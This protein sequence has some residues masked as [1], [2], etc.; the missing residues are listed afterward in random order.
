MF[1]EAR[2]WA[3]RV[4]ERMGLQARE[5]AATELVEMMIN[6]A[7]MYK[8][9]MRGTAGAQITQP[10]LVL[11]AVAAMSDNR[12]AFD[13]LK[14]ARFDAEQLLAQARDAGRQLALENGFHETVRRFYDRLPEVSAQALSQKPTPDETLANFQ[15]QQPA[16]PHKTTRLRWW[17]PLAVAAFFGFYHAFSRPPQ[18]PDSVSTSPGQPKQQVNEVDPWPWRESMDAMRSNDGKTN[19][20]AERIAALLNQPPSTV[21]EQPSNFSSFKLPR[22]VEVQIPKGWW[23]LG[24]EHLRIIATTVEAAM[25][26]S[27]VGLP[28]GQKVTLIAANSMPRSTYAAIRINSTTPPSM[29]RTDVMSVTTAEIA[30]ARAE[31]RQNLAKLLQIQG[32]QLLEVLGVRVETIGG[33]PAM[34]TEY[35]RTGPEGAVWAQINQVFTEQQEIG[36]NLSYRESEAMLW[37]PVVAKMRQ[38]I[39]VKP[40]R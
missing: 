5:P 29:T 34:V 15:R 16:I 31:L 30:A 19:F 36:I 24:S 22:G 8:D 33:Y 27:S 23:I 26:L 7:K 20:D 40:W 6:G 28:E 10:E 35:R 38:S 1:F 32:N 3:L 12:S 37:K 18:A 13:R 25:D 2:R 9:M 17:L 4:T 11:M 14:R 21:T 39:V